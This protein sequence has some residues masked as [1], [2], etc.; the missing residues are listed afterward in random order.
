MN[1]R[2][3][4]TR[5]R[6][7]TREAGGLIIFT[8]F[9]TYGINGPRI[10]ADYK[11]PIG[12]PFT[13]RTPVNKGSNHARLYRRLLAN[14]QTVSGMFVRRCLP[15]ATWPTAVDVLPALSP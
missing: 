4:R 7:D 9:Q 3:A 15:T 10:R 11:L 14:G 1:V 2:H 6:T 8:D 12:V 13:F 5:G